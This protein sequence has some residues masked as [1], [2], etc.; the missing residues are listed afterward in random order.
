MSAK[1]L[2]TDDAQ[3]KNIKEE[4]AAQPQSIV[5]S[6]P[7]VLKIKSSL[8][9]KQPKKLILN[10]IQ[11]V[12]VVSVQPV[13]TEYQPV[14]SD[15]VPRL[16]EFITF[17]KYLIE[18]WYSAPY[19]HEYVQKSVLH[20]CE[21]CLKYVRTKEVL[22]LHMQKKCS[23]YQNKCLNSSLY[24]SPVKQCHLNKFKTSPQELEYDSSKVLSAHEL[25]STN[26]NVRASAAVWSPLNPPGN[27][28]YR[29]TSGKLSV[30]EVDG[31]TSKIYC[32]NLCLLAKLFLDHKTLYYDVEPFLF[33]VLTQNDN[34]GC[35]LVGYFSKEKHCA[36]K[37]N[38]SCIMVMPQYQ[39]SGYG[40]FL[41]DFS[42]LLSRVEGQP[43]S[44]EKPLSDLGRLS[45]ESYWRSIVLEYLYSFRIKLNEYKMSHETN[46]V[47]VKQE[48]GVESLESQRTTALTKPPP[49]SSIEFSLRKM[50]METGVCV[51][52]L[53]STL[54]YLNLFVLINSPAAKTDK[55][56]KI[57]FINLNSNLIDQHMRKLNEIP[58]EKRLALKLD[59][60]CLIW[61]PFISYHLMSAANLAQESIKT[62]D[63]DVQVCENDFVP[64]KSKHNFDEEFSEIRELC[65]LSKFDLNKESLKVINSLAL[66]QLGRKRGRKRKSLVSES[67]PNNDDEN[68]NASQLNMDNDS[69]KIMADSMIAVT[70]SIMNNSDFD[71]NDTSKN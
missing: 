11:P 64:K 29:S 40:R 3:C 70:D 38:V 57:F 52:D 34:Y 37:Y 48:E 4:P 62:V 49:K 69:S 19:P 26:S 27:E 67:V 71:N 24:D 22:K 60:Q 42:F 17:G 1:A 46:L 44:P 61:S 7:I 2:K 66:K 20:I 51:Q 58:L 13:N 65:D 30:F 63:A 6:E 56:K 31:N 21:F 54:Q 41:I 12:A 68:T 47:E 50:S 8:N 36:Q 35:H 18:T 28:I 16:P 55:N 39:R 10:P 43:G 45:Y 15:I 33:Y 23:Q 59:P 9:D 25:R 53:A 32:Q 5:Q 14:V